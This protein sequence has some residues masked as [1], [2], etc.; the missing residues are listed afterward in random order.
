[1]MAVGLVEAAFF[2][3]IAQR[4]VE[5][6]APALGDLGRLRTFDEGFGSPLAPLTSAVQR[7]FSYSSRSFG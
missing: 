1:M 5:D 3:N 7:Y 4:V 2:I 6:P